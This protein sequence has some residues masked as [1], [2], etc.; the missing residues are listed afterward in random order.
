MLRTRRTRWTILSS[1]FLLILLISE[2]CLGRIPAQAQTSPGQPVHTPLVAL[3]AGVEENARLGGAL[4]LFEDF[5]RKPFQAEEIFGT[6]RKHVTVQF[7]YRSVGIPG[8]TD[9]PVIVDQ[10]A[11]RENRNG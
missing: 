3:T 4:D 10:Q 6:I 5:V 9:G 2:L 1:I 11:R 7:I 8:V